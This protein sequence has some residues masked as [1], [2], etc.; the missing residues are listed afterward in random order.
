MFTIKGV[1]NYIQSQIDVDVNGGGMGVSGTRVTIYFENGEFTGINEEARKRL[2][3]LNIG[4]DV[5]IKF[6][7]MVDEIVLENG[8][9]IT[10][11]HNK[12]IE[13]LNLNTNIIGDT[14][15]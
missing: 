8:G 3:N 15:E 6:Y 4:T 11:A 2:S 13:E 10:E 7:K 5:L 14:N 1:S 12:V 9:L